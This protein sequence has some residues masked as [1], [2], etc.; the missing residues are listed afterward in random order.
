MKKI[1][2]LTLLVGI[3]CCVYAQML[4]KAEARQLKTFLIQSSENGVTNA[5]ALKVYNVDKL[6]N[7]EGIVIQNGHVISIKWVDKH[8]SGNLDLS[9]FK[10]LK[11]VDVSRN[12]LSSLSVA[13]NPSLVDLNASKNILTSVDFSNCP[14][15]KSVSIQKNRLTEISIVSS[16]LISLFICSFFAKITN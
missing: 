12:K 4:D 6:S 15:L 7:V 10:M 5:D 14:E 13:N 8:L 16:P 1:L 2:L 3:S 9:S 11:S